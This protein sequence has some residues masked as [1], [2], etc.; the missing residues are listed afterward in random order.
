MKPGRLFWALFFITLG[1]LG[2]LANLSWFRPEWHAITKFWPV[3]LVLLGLAF[4]V[5]NEFGKRVLAG[6]AGL[7]AAL[8]LFVLFH[9]GWREVD[10]L[11]S[12]DRSWRN[13]IHQELTEQYTPGVRHV[14]FSFESGAGSFKLGDTTSD[15]IAATVES[16]LGKYQLT[17]THSDSAEVVKL[18]MPE[19]THSFNFGRNKNNVRVRLN[20]LPQWDMDIDVGAA[21]VDFDLSQYNTRTVRLNTGATSIDLIMG[22]KAPDA[23]LEIDA[24]A[25]SVHIRIPK[26]V[27]CEIR[28]DAELSSKDFEGFEQKDSGEWRTVGYGSSKKTMTIDID[29][30]VSSLHVERY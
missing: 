24:G 4:L 16:S 3:V 10:G 1:A 19:G 14:N 27:D 22:D 11:M 5:R 15:L 13:V 23:R 30:G 28:C 2:L 21:D 17:R 9:S 7:L 29:A 18:E 6:G 8:V 25:A 20:P 12:S 26:S